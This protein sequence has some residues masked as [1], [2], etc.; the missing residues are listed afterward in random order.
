MENLPRTSEIPDE[1]KS[2]IISFNNQEVQQM[3]ARLEEIKRLKKTQKERELNTKYLIKETDKELKN[4]TK[5]EEKPDDQDIGIKMKLKSLLQQLS[6]F[7][8]SIQDNSIMLNTLS[9]KAEQ[10]EDLISKLQNVKKMHEQVD[11]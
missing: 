2:D 11:K 1:I 7:D 10:T 4:I 6:E 5:K 3:Y 9:M 8:K